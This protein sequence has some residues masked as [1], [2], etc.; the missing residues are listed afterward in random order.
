[1]SRKPLLMLLKPFDIYPRRHS[2]D[3]SIVTNPHTP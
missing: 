2:E 1:M 3:L